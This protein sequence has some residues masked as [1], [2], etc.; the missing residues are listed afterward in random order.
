LIERISPPNFILNDVMVDPRDSKRLLIATDRGGIFASDDAGQTFHP[1]NDGFSQRQV[2]SVIAD[3]KEPSDLYVSVVKTRNSAVSS[4]ATM[5]AGR[6]SSMVWAQRRSSTWSARRKDISLRQPIAA[7][8][9]CL[10][11]L[12]SGSPA[13]RF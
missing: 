12:S 8:T 10:R 2:T 13:G 11:A 6:N 3:P 7:C 5:G 1:S 4:A 9:G